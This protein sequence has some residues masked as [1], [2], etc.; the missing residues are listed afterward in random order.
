MNEERVELLDIALKTKGASVKQVV[1]H[2]YWCSGSG[3]YHALIPAAAEAW[4]LPVSG[5]TASEPQRITDALSS[6]KLD[7]WTLANLSDDK[8][9][10]W[11]Q[12]KDHLTTDPA[13]SPF[14]LLDT[15]T[16]GAPEDAALI[17][18]GDCEL[19]YEDS[20]YQ[21][22]TFASAADVHAAAEAAR[23]ES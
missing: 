18:R 6:G 17:T 9:P 22:Y 15:E 4:G 14:L 1:E 10:D 13:G 11:L 20:R 12:K 19:V 21:V 3:S 7:V 23:A 5:Y 2:G 8:V 16:D